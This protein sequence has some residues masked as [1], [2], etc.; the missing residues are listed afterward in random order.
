MCKT[1][2]SCVPDRPVAPPTLPKDDRKETPPSGGV[3]STDSHPFRISYQVTLQ[4]LSCGGNTPKCSAAGY[5]CSDVALRAP[6]GSYP[7]A[8][9]VDH[10]VPRDPSTT[11]SI[12]SDS[13]S[14]AR[15]SPTESNT[16]PIGPDKQVPQPESQRA[17]DQKRPTAPADIAA[18]CMDTTLAGYAVTNGTL[19]KGAN[20]EDMKVYDYCTSTT[21][22]M[23]C[24]PEEGKPKS[25]TPKVEGTDE[26]NICRTLCTC[27]V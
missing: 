24:N 11:E 10:S 25:P 2:C 15:E 9:N 26:A 3:S 5:Y 16:K 6:D 12:C 1:S 21:V 8:F 14:C 23:K 27:P 7:H 20:S 4:V 17:E 18:T 22:N 19:P 13:C